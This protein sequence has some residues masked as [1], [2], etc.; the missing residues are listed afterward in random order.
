MKS[1]LDLNLLKVI[2]LLVK[3]RQL[4][5]VAKELGKTESAISKH[6]AKLREQLGDQLFVRST[7]E[8]EP[9]EFTL[10]LLPKVTQGLE[11]I[12]EAVQPIE[13]DPASY[14]K[15]IVIALPSLYQYLVGKKL[16]IDLIEM[17]PKAQVHITT[18]SDSS[19][20]DIHEETLDI[21]IQYFNPELSKTIYQQHLGKLEGAVICADGYGQRTLED[22]LK[23]RFVLMEMKGWQ[24]KKAVIKRALEA[25]GMSINKIATVDNITCLF[26]V[27]NELECATLLPA[28][29]HLEAM[30][31]YTIE[32]L[33]KHLQPEHPMSV[34]AN[35]KLVNHDNPLHR[36]LADK[37]KQHLL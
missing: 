4:R 34:V 2:P 15:P 25:H 22:K 23:M 20:Q 18:W 8:F 28:S 30:P 32:I 17:F 10:S 29:H 19:V 33:P 11:L 27:L 35:Y 5:P 31:G 26:E 14:E 37:L 6:L 12:D 3:H 7:F 24:D 1:Q 9:T 36:L 13:F 16:L 21:G